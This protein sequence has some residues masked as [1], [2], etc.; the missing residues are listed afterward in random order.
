MINFIVKNDHVPMITI[1]YIDYTNYQ[2]L[3]N[4]DS[5][6]AG[7]RLIIVKLVRSISS[8]EVEL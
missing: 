1:I 2:L 6:E 4:G 3:R 8:L 5:W 7:L